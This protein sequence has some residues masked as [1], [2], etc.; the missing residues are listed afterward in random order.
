M[1]P[2]ACPRKTCKSL[3]RP[4]Y[5]PPLMSLLVTWGGISTRKCFAAA[6]RVTPLKSP[7]PCLCVKINALAPMHWVQ[8]R[9]IVSPSGQCL[10]LT[11]A[12]GV[13]SHGSKGPIT[14]HFPLGFRQVAGRW[15]RPQYFPTQPLLSRMR[16]KAVQQKHCLEGL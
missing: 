14:C 13:W 11:V 7:P 12:C 16:F 4:V 5:T 10:V 15:A 9:S 6:G 3:G 2:G 8:L 1:Q